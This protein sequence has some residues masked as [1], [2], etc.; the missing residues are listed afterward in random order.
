MGLIWQVIF[1][2]TQLTIFDFFCGSR[3]E[4]FYRC[5]PGESI[6]V[7]ALSPAEVTGSQDGISGGMPG[8]DEQKVR[9]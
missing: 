8:Y 5:A 3:G 4:Y 2:C 6:P 9:I 7:T 1:V